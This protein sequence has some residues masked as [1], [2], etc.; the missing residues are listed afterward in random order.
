MHSLAGTLPYMAPEQLE[1][2]P[3]NAKADAWA[4]GIILYELCC[5][6][7]PFPSSN[8]MELMRKLSVCQPEPFLESV[9]NE[10]KFLIQ[11]LLT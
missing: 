11:S 8:P 9:F 7:H 1:G 10:T 4:M 5:G 2:K 3:F 6:K